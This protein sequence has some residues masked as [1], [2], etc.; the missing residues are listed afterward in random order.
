MW[1]KVV[2]LVSLTE[3]PLRRCLPLYNPIPR[4][5]AILIFED[6]I[7]VGVSILADIRFRLYRLLLEAEPLSMPWRSGVNIQ[8]V[9]VFSFV[10]R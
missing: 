1:I 9:T 4:I 2:L 7:E 10:M 8:K 6:G 3:Q 5:A